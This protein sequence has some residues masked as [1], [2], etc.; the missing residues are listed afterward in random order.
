M[1]KEDLMRAL[2]DEIIKDL[3]SLYHRSSDHGHPNILD[4]IEKLKKFKEKEL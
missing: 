2:I 1:T 4:I 3:E